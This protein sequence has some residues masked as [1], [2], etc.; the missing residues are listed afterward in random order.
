MKLLNNMAIHVG[1][2]PSQGAPTC[3]EL[4]IPAQEIPQDSP[5]VSIVIP[6]LNEVMTIGEFVMWC[7]EGLKGANIS[8][9]III[10]DSSSDATPCIALEKGARVLRTPKCGLGQAYIDAIPF[11]R[12]KF[13]LMGDCDLTYDFR[14][15]KEFVDSYKAGNEFVMG[16]RFKG[17]IEKGAMPHLHRYFGT[18]LTTWILNCIYKGKFSDIHC[19]MRGLTKNTLLKINLTSS[20]WEYASEMVLKALRL[21]VK[22]DEVPVTFYKDREGRV[23][24]HRRAGFWSPWVAGWINVKVMLIYS[25]DTFLIKPGMGLMVFGFLLCSGLALGPIS[26][27]SIGLNAHWMLLG[28]T[29]TVLGFALLQMGIFARITHNFRVGIDKLVIKHLSYNRGMFAASGAVLTGLLININFFYHYII[30]GFRLT[31][32]SYTAIFGVLLIMIGAQT[33][34]FTLL[35]ELSRRLKGLRKKAK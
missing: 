34:A 21:R 4:F 17:K 29:S 24:H 3:T 30:N 32:F 2:S 33:F 1:I 15:I 10:I 27:G 14:E 16:S 9:E 31:A 25:P 19:G 11:I 20:S 35:I 12:G 26:I 7:W 8:G 18:P 6:A 5:E 28:V 13:I 22:I 23:S